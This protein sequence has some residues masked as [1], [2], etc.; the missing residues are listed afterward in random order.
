MRRIHA[1]AERVAAWRTKLAHVQTPTPLL[2]LDLFT[3]N[4]YWTVQGVQRRPDVHYKTAQRA[5][6]RI[7]KEAIVTQVGEAKRNRVYCAGELLAIL[8]APVVPV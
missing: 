8:D 6:E 2:A 4:P 1:V 7:E 5:I 3:E